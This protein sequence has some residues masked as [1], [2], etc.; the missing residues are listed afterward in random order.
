MAFILIDEPDNRCRSCVQGEDRF[1]H[2]E[3]RPVSY[4]SPSPPT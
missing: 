4:R 1:R 2:E 3:P